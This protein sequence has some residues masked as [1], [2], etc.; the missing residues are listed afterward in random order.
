MKNQM[1]KASCF[2]PTHGRPELLEEAIESFLRQDYQGPKELVILNDCPDQILVFEH[3]E[4]VVVNVE[5]PILPLGKKFNETVKLCTGDILFP[6]DDDDIY[7]PWKLSYSIEQMK[8]GLFHT[9][10]AWLDNGI[11]NLE[12]VNNLFQCNLAIS[13]ERWQAIGGYLEQDFGAIDRDLFRRLDA[14]CVSQSIPRNRWFYI[15]RWEGSGSYH[16]SFMGSYRQGVSRKAHQYFAEQKES[17]QLQCGTVRLNPHWRKDWLALQDQAASQG[18]KDDS[19]SNLKQES[20]QRPVEFFIPLVK[21]IPLGKS[22]V[23]PSKGVKDLVMLD[24]MARLIWE[25]LVNK[26]SVIDIA[27]VVADAYGIAFHDAF[28]DVRGIIYDWEKMEL[29]EQ[30][31]YLRWY[32]VHG[33]AIVIDCAEDK[34]NQLV[35]TALQQFSSPQL[36]HVDVVFRVCRQQGEYQ[37]FQDRE[38]VYQSYYPDSVAQRLI[39]D[40]IEVC[41]RDRDYIAVLHAAAVSCNGLQVLMPGKGGFGKTTLA[42]AL[43][44][45]GCHCLADDIVPLLSSDGEVAPLSTSLCIKQG[46]LSLLEP[47]YPKIR[48]LPALYRNGQV[49]R[50][51]PL[52]S[53]KDVVNPVC[54]IDYIIYPKRDSNTKPGLHPLTVEQAFERL[55]ASQPWL[56]GQ[57]YEEKVE[58]LVDWVSKTPAFEMTYHHLDQACDM[59]MGFLCQSNTPKIETVDTDL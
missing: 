45:K 28:S 59:V 29:V 46:S 15:Y 16:T 22:M 41:Y 6:W 20:S 52:K 54:T 38:L 31:R 57:G 43:M 53:P 39:F 32:Q 3:P 21:G 47:F 58:Q 19:N 4:V 17:G 55:V 26:M 12:P 13:R 56:D 51:L 37:L 23:L 10:D 50:Y 7:L 30:A 27:S 9:S 44:A 48:Q 25:G 14:R 24:P 11:D 40:F 42:A 5:Q 18:G 33:R 35:G 36:S 34:V 8:D 49:V 2:C 1:L